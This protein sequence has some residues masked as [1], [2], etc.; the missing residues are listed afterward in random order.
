[1]MSVSVTS[2]QQATAPG[3]GHTAQSLPSGYWKELQSSDHV[4]ISIFHMAFARLLISY[5]SRRTKP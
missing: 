1:M 4:L 2:K 3:L 5:K